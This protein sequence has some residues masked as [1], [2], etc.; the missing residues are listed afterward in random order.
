MTV[1]SSQRSSAALP[2]AV[3]RRQGWLGQAWKRQPLGVIAS[4]FILL[5]FVLGVLAPVIAPFK[6]GQQDLLVTLNGP[7]SAHWLGTDALGRDILSRLLYAAVPSLTYALIALAVFL[8]IGV[9]LGIV[10]G[11]RGGRIDSVISRVAEIAMSIPAVII[12]LVVL[13]VFSSSPIAAMITLGVLGS[14]GLIR[15]V[16]GVTLVVREEAYVTAATVAG[17]KPV[18]IM[19]THLVRR[20]LG[21]ILVQASVFVGSALVIQA[22]LAF[23]GLLSDGDRPTWGGM[24]GE[25]SQVISLTSWPLVPAGLIIILTVM[26]FGLVGDAIRDATS[27]EASPAGRR[28]R[29]RRAKTVTPAANQFDLDTKNH[30]LQVRNLRVS[31]DDGV[32]L[33]DDATFSVAQ[34]EIVAVVGE[35]GCGKS[36]TALGTLGLLPPGL[37]VDGGSVIFDG[38][39]LLSRGAEAYA[40]VRGG[41]IGYVAQ[42]ALGSLDPTHTVE[43]HLREVILR[44]EKL[45]PAKLKQ[46]THELLQ[47]VQ[48]ADPARVL[49]LYPHEISGGMAQRINIALALAGRPRLIIADEPTT[50]LDV[51]VQSEILHLLR[52]LQQ[53][54]KL[55]V[56]IITHNWGVVADMADRA[57]V[58]YAGE[59]VEMGDVYT[60]FQAPRF[61]YTAALLAADPSV[62]PLGKRLETIPGRVPAPGSRPTGCRFAGRCPFATEACLD[63]PLPLRV[64]PPGSVTRCIRAE[65]LASEGVL[66][67]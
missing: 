58:M 27:D 5:I 61:P 63:G 53:S 17:V 52:E 46:R 30:L 21:P 65:E 16:R 10:A 24:I 51:T 4:I 23:L 54:T 20:A 40:A 32:T 55:S 1:T 7:S 38:V 25:A 26:A 8:L 29:R 57:V 28:W 49:K 9:P 33:V 47:Q 36:V 44:H 50:A 14:P 43:G 56:L 15:V 13:A 45:S 67:R 34:G 66:D 41:G 37:H 39:D 42:D 22:A 19:A 2:N 18:N 60:V 35:S 48:I 3:P 31:V 6:A 12:L 64:V 62:S 59:V 11:Y